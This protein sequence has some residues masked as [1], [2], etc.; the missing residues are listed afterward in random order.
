MT[1][2]PPSPRGDELGPP[3][4]AVDSLRNFHL[5]H[6]WVCQRFRNFGEFL[7]KKTVGKEK[8]GDLLKETSKKSKR[9]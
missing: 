3:C 9:K 4:L 8:F 2:F 7:K 6:P 5:H 1:H